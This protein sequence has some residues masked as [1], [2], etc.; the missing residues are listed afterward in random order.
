[1]KLNFDSNIKSGGE[2][3]E[4]YMYYIAYILVTKNWGGKATYCS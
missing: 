3:K 1:M 4:K 2:R